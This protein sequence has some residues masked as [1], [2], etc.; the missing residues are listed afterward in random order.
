MTEA[1]SRI[2]DFARSWFQ[3]CGETWGTGILVSREPLRL[4]WRP[5]RTRYSPGSLVRIGADLAIVREDEA[6]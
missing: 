6:A 4:P 2:I 5:G 3:E 1:P